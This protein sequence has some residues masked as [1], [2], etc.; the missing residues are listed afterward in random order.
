M[1]NSFLLLCSA[2]E[3]LIEKLSQQ[4]Q[5][6]G[7]DA[8]NI[9]QELLTAPLDLNL[10][11]PEELRRL[12][13][14]ARLQVEAFLSHRKTTIYYSKLADALSAL[15]VSGDTLALC[16]SVFIVSVPQSLQSDKAW[17][18]RL[19]WRVARPVEIDAR[20][21]G[22]PYRS[23]QSVQIQ[24]GEIQAGVLL[25]RDP[26]ESNWADHMVHYVQWQ[27]QQAHSGWKIVLGNYQVE[28]GHGLTFWSSY[29]SSISTDAQAPARLWARGVR[30]FLSA[31]ENPSLYG[32]ALL[33]R[34]RVCHFLGF[35]SVQKRD[36]HLRDGI[37]AVRYNSSGYH[38]SAREIAEQNNLQE[39]AWGG[40]VQI[41]DSGHSLGLLIYAAEYSNPWQVDD[42]AAD[43]FAFTGRRYGVASITGNWQGRDLATSFE[44]ATSHRGGKAGSLVFAGEQKRWAW[45]LALH[46]FEVNFHSPHGLGPAANH[47]SSAG[48]SGYEAGLTAKPFATITGEFHY[49][50]SQTLWRTSTLPLPGPRHRFGGYIEWHAQ[51]QLHFTLRYYRNGNEYLQGTGLA[52]SQQMPQQVENVRIEL[53]QWF[54]SRFRLRPRLNFARA[55]Q[56]QAVLIPAVAA[57]APAHAWRRRETAG[58]WG[59]ALSLDF[60]WKI[61]NSIHLSLR[62][63]IF[64]TAVPI[65]DYENDLPGIFT[66]QAL[67]ERGARRYIYLHLKTF[68]HFELSSK[69][70]ETERQISVFRLQKELSWGAQID[71]VR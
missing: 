65:Y 63:V 40:G 20:W 5:E 59:T 53:S 21:P 29:R 46:R 58:R 37:H 30:P 56:Q 64:D 24:R 15:R 22:P 19:R 6:S 66:V 8:E 50:R 36:A 7:D 33:R 61:S 1:F 16:R 27:K 4:E 55:L 13:F 68:G 45:T 54:D 28:W 52:F 26:G 51:A 48:G 44:I 2:Q 35:A 11:T 17:H 9:L 34:S 25:E 71:W 12:P 43:F 23:Y 57:P 47:N 41:G 18:G 62:H 42:A 39:K 32:G 3:A 14:L 69:I 38:R 60:I 31:Y 10:A 67:R 49:Q 70:A